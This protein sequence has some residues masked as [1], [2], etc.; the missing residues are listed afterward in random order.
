MPV[1]AKKSDNGFS[2]KYR[3]CR[4]YRR[5]HFGYQYDLLIR[6][7][8]TDPQ[9][10]S[11]GTKNSGSEFAPTFNFGYCTGS[12]AAQ[13]YMTKFFNVAQR[14][15]YGRDWAKQYDRVWPI[16]YGYFEHPDTN[17][18]YHVLA[19]VDRPLADWIEHMVRPRG[20]NIAS[21]WAA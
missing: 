15:V 17:P 12:I 7:R 2:V 4:Y 18:H 14:E 5:L 3:Y 9:G 21:A 19:K 16:A 1:H 6:P 11:S 8:Q 20:K 13:S 10:T